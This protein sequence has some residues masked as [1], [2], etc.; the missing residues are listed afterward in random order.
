VDGAH[1]DQ[2][3]AAV[4]GRP[5]DHIDPRVENEADG[6]SEK[7][8]RHGWRVGSEHE[9]GAEP[10]PEE[11]PQRGGDAPA[12]IAVTLRD[13]HEARERSLEV[14]PL[15]H[16]GEGNDG[17]RHGPDAIERVEKERAL[18]PCGLAGR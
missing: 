11:A 18:E 16:R 17:R 5:H 9:D 6:P 12:E 14:S 3:V 2:V 15:R 10:A 13:E 8:D 4:L 7:G 1:P